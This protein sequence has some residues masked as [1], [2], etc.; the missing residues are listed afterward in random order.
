MR[1]QAY[2]V[3]VIGGLLFLAGVA[4]LV[5]TWAGWIPPDMPLLFTN[6]LVGA[7]VFAQVLLLVGAVLVGVDERLRRLEQAPGDSSRGSP[8]GPPN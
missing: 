3:F 8:P 2:G 4:G 1:L 6:Y 5:A 7:L